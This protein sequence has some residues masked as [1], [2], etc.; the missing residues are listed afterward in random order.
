GAGHN[1]AA[2]KAL[3]RGNDPRV[4]GGHN[5]AV[6]FS[7][8]AGALVNMLNQVFSR[9]AQQRLARQPAGVITGGNNNGG[10]HARPLCRKVR[11]AVLDSLAIRSARLNAT[12]AG[13][14]LS[15]LSALFLRSFFEPERKNTFLD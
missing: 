8:L 7:S 5:Y 4:V 14:R 2:V 15:A 6:N 11:E 1:R 12:G 9:L 3:H 13:S 10:F